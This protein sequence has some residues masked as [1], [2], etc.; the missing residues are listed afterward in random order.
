MPAV[1]F[2]FDPHP[3]QR[4]SGPSTAPV[5][6]TTPR[7]RAE[8]LLALGVDAVLVQP[9]DQALVALEAE[10]FYTRTSSA[11]GS[12][13][14]GRRRGAR[15]P[16]RRPPRAATWRCWRRSAGATASSSTRVARVVAGGER[17]SSSRLRRLIAAGDVP[18]GQRAADGALPAHGHGRR[19]R[20]PRRDD[21]LPDGEP[22]RRSPRSCPAAG[23][24]AARAAV[25]DGVAAWPA[26]VHVGPNVSFGETAISVEAH[27]I[28]FAGDLYGRTLDVDFLDR[29]R[30]TRRFASID[31]LKAQLGRRRR[32]A[33]AVAAAPVA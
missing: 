2:T 24:Y 14:A 31:D 10:A 8:L 4:R 1:V 13:A 7:R 25:A 26:A 33:A 21:R 12:R 5:P 20:A 6:L 18:R 23:V 28:G 30:D 3:G 29:L 27:L 19:R 15:L 22:R 9:A 17:V 16:L 32:A 11:A